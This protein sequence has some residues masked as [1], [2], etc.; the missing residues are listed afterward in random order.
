MEVDLNLALDLQEPVLPIKGPLL[1]LFIT[2]VPLVDHT[3][4]ILFQ[5]RESD[6]LLFLGIEQASLEALKV[7]LSRSCMNLLFDLIHL[8]FHSTEPIVQSFFHFGGV[9]SAIFRDL[10]ALND[11]RSLLCS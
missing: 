7:N 9:Y 2:T 8:L 6:F 1:D 11:V 5:L 3:L 4:T 10:S